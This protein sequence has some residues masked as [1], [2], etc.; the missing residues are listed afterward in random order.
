[1]SRLRRR[2]AGLVPGPEHA[3][4]GVG[5]RERVHLGALR[6]L[7]LYVLSNLSKCNGQAAAVKVPSR[8]PVL[9]RS[10]QAV[11]RVR[12]QAGII[13]AERALAAEGLAF[14]LRG[15][16]P[17]GGGHGGLPRAKEFSGEAER[18]VLVRRPELVLP[19][20]HE[21]GQPGPAAKTAAA[22]GEVSANDRD[23]SPELHLV[24]SL[25][26]VRLPRNGTLSFRR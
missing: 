21:P 19:V 13:P 4:H 18:A 10:V 7:H 5:G 6:S 11:G 15:G 26:S 20:V 8:D 3:P 16:T 25:P 22:Q 24:T 14:L 9:L 1:M 2:E 23:P 12:G 17:V